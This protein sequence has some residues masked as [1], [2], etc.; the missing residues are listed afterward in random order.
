M[1]SV[2]TILLTAVAILAITTLAIISPLLLDVLSVRLNI[3][4]QRVSELGQSYGAASALLSAAALGVLAVSTVVQIRQTKVGQLHAVRSFQLELLRM[5][6][7][8]P[9][10]REA[11]GVDLNALNVSEWRR[12]AYLNL[13]VMY[14]QMNFLI[15]AIDEPGLRRFLSGEFFNGPLGIGYWTRSRSAIAA[16][17]GTRRHKLFVRITEDEYE[18]AIARA[19]VAAST[20]KHDGESTAIIGV[21]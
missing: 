3:D 7:D 11:L 12:H 5:A 13:W 4:S 21:G 17:G 15:G 9:E 1:R 14:F 16:E 19:P 18:K 8:N 2:V 20:S 6:L 10:Y